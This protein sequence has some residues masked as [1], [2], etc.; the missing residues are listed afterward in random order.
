M[1]DAMHALS[2]RCTPVGRL[3][4]VVE[5]RQDDRLETW[6][7]VRPHSSCA[8]RCEE[9]GMALTPGCRL[10]VDA[11]SLEPIGVLEPALPA[12]PM[13]AGYNPYFDLPAA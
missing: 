2:D 6:L 1:L 3:E 8:P 11:Q 9:P 12:T 10:V 4:Y 5:S 7:V 13:A